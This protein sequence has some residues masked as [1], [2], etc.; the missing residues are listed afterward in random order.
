MTTEHR[1]RVLPHLQTPRKVY[2]GLHQQPCVWVWMWLRVQVWVCT[3]M[4]AGVGGMG[5]V[6]VRTNPK[7][8]FP[9]DCQVV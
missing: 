8:T 5:G 9:A 4:T 2:P 6:D 1:D 7:N 3:S